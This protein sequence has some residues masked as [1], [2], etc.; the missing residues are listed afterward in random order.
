M[1]LTYVAI[2]YRWGW[3]NNSWYLIY[4]GPDKTKAVALASQ[5]CS[6]RGGK[7]GCEVIQTGEDGTSENFVAYFPSIYGESRCHVNHKI[8]MFSNIGHRAADAADGLIYV[9]NED[10]KVGILRPAPVEPPKWLK[11]I[12]EK[13]EAMCK[14]LQSISDKHNPPNVPKE[15]K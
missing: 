5:E 10:E 11:E 14:T 12:V 2:A 8:Q 9:Q 3:T 7:Y 15:G 6:D 1:N 4:A 13:E